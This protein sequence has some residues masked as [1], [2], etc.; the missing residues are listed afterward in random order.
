MKKNYVAYWSLFLEQNLDL[1][2]SFKSLFLKMVAFRP[3]ERPSIDDILNDE[4]MK[5]INNLND[6][7]MNILE[8]EVRQELQNRRNN[9]N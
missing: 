1:S 8:N 9:H 2:N 6:G 4:W 3:E 7:D 5:E